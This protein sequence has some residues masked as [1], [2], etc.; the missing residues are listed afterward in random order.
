MGN[1]SGKEVAAMKRHY[2]LSQS[3]FIALFISYMIFPILATYVFSIA[4]RW[5]RTILPE[6]YTFEWYS[7][8][9]VHPYFISTL[10]NSFIVAGLSVMLGLVLVGPTAYWVHARLPGAKP[11]LDVL[12]ILPFGIPGVVLALALIR[13]YSFPPIARSPFLLV[14]ACVIFSMPFLYRPISNSLGA[15]NVKMLTESA[16]SLGANTWQILRRVIIPN[17][18]P[19]ILSGCLLVFSTV[20]A[21]FTLANLITGAKFKTFPILLVEF[22]RKDGRVASALSVI[23]FT[24]AWMVSLLIIWAAGKEIKSGEETVRAH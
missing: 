13:V 5:D 20:F 18:M 2:P 19:G 14:S 9:F 6:G 17:I 16:Q 4:T 12:T 24:I 11:I 22:T 3:I 1:S 7:T 23:S 10:K 21:E 8:A 15:V